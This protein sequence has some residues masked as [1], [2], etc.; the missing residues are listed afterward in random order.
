MSARQGRNVQHLLVS[1]GTADISLST[2]Q[3]SS[4]TA[5]EIGAFDAGGLRIVEASA[6]A[7]E[8]N[9]SEG[10]DFFL[11][12]GGSSPM[13]RTPLIR[14]NK[15]KSMAA[16]AYSAPTEQSDYIGYNGSTGSIEVFDNN[17]YMVDVYVEDYL[18][19]SHDGRYIK[20]F[21]Y[22]SDAT[23][24][25]AEIAIGLAVSAYNN[26]SREAKDTNGDPF[27]T[28]KAVCNEAASA[29]ND[30]DNNVS[31]T[32]GS[33]VFTVATNLQ[34]NG[35]AGT[36]AAGDFIRIASTLNGT[37]ALTDS[38]YRVESI[39]GLEVT[40]DRPIA[41]PSGTWTDAGDGTQVITAATGASNNW[42][43]FMTG[44]DKPYAVGKEFHKK[45]R[46]NYSLSQFGTTTQTSNATA[47]E[48]VGAV[49][50]VSDLEWFCKGNQG[51][52]FRMGEPTI[53][54]YTSDVN[55]SVQGGGYD[56]LDIVY[57]DDSVVGFQANHSPIMVTLATQATAPDF[58]TNG[59][60]GLR[61]ILETIA[62]TSIIAAGGL[63]V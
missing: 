21:Q 12:L 53:H 9:V 41:E 11:A 6:G 61:D 8:V 52:Y 5:N 33:K 36:L 46:Y 17:L 13:Q 27:M 4:L 44:V 10:M 51:E 54:G 22:E 42:G 20:H 60:D 47:D 63:D 16:T 29:T 28:F 18:T 3:F 24:T 39:S 1:S 56:M 14:G 62:G 26:W 15:I 43:V 19:S 34:Y 30:F 2:G 31:I 45:I 49:N 57:E 35:G 37:L 7:G 25:Q 58:M 32:S 48:G 55:S 59:T 38:V 50:A 40:V 23:A